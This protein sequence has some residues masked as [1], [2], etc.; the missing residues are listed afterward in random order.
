VR[1]EGRGS[2]VLWNIVTAHKF[3]FYIVDISYIKRD[4]MPGP[5]STWLG[6]TVS[7]Y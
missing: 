1:V 2:R 3:N 7:L 5:A 4:M 6:L